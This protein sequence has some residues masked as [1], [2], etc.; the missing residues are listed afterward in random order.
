MHSAARRAS[1]DIDAYGQACA[2]IP[3][4]LAPFQARIIAVMQMSAVHVETMGEALRAVR[5]TYQMADDS[6]SGH[7]DLLARYR[8][9]DRQI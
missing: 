7:L 9:A 2:F 8:P 3:A 4:N 5:T 6:V 1:L